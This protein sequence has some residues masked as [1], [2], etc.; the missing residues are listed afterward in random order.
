MR[1]YL[2]FDA[3][4]NCIPIT[5]RPFEH[6]VT[7][8]SVIRTHPRLAIDDHPS[9][10]EARKAGDTRFIVCNPH[11]GLSN[12]RVRKKLARKLADLVRRH[13]AEHLDR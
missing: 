11:A 8:G 1:I 10:V 9:V 12:A 6:S 5:K 13:Q 2:N 4:L 7:F 3:V